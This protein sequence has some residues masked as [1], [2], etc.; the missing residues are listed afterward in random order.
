[1]S[2]NP[3]TDPTAIDTGVNTAKP[4]ANPEGYDDTPDNDPGN[5]IGVPVFKTPPGFIDPKLKLVDRG[6]IAGPPPSTHPN[7]LVAL[8]TSRI[9]NM[10]L[11]I[12]IR[13]NPALATEIK[14]PQSRFAPRSRRV[15][16]P[17]RIG[18]KIP[19][20]RDGSND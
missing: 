19:G 12:A 2:V 9:V 10:E 1:M 14:E 15:G 16:H 7:T 8:V 13:D 5:Q 3:T 18:R 11:S 4:H 17:G 20:R 6:Q